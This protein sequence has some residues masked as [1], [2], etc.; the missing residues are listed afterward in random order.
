[1]R[2]PV[3]LGHGAV[4]AHNV[5][6]GRRDEA[7]IH[8]Q[9]EWGLHVER[10]A[11]GEADELR[12]PRHLRVMQQQRACQRRTARRSR[13]SDPSVR[14]CSCSDPSMSAPPPRARSTRTRKPVERYKD[15]NCDALMTEDV[16]EGELKYAIED[17]V[18][19]DV[20]LSAATSENTEA[21]VRHQDLA[22][23]ENCPSEQHLAEV[24]AGP[25]DP[26]QCHSVSDYE[27]KLELYVHAAEDVEAWDHGQP[28]IFDERD[29]ALSYYMFL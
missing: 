22:G 2:V 13:S 25:P 6:G 20:T 17:S 19:S 14:A 21:F 8:Q 12:M 15:D 24:E 28:S 26:K 4:V 11:A 27:Q 23:F 16:D 7:L 9:G 18:S 5:Q 10:V 1:M 29:T 3:N